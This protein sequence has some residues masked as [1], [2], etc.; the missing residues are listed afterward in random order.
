MEVKATTRSRHEHEISRLDQLRTPE[1]QR[2]LLASVQLEESAM[3]AQSVVTLVDEVLETIR[4]APAARDE[5][6]AKM[7]ALDW[8]DEMRRSPELVRFHL[9]E[10]QIFE[11]DEEFPQLPADFALP[12]GVL[13]LKYTISLANLPYLDVAA[14][15]ADI[16]SAIS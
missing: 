14:V 7:D 16:A 6:L 5:F 3:G 1:D 11:V 2:L 12:A 8:S 4:Q 9:R 13:A 10:A 15:R